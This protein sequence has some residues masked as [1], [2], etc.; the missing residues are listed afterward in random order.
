MPVILPRDAEGEWLDR[1]ETEPMAVLGLLQ[2]YPEDL[3]TG[4][5][6]SSAVNRVGSDGPELVRP[7]S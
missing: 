6:V 2:P 7:L 1:G 4:Y 5:P 3:M